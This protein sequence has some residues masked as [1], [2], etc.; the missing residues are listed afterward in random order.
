MAYSCG[1]CG[2]W[3]N[4]SESYCPGCRRGLRFPG[5]STREGCVVFGL[6]VFGV[7]FFFGSLFHRAHSA[8]GIEAA[9]GN[10]TYLPLILAIGGVFYA[11]YRGRLGPRW[12]WGVLIASVPIVIGNCGDRQ[13]HP[14]DP[15]PSDVRQWYAS[16]PGRL[17]QL[18]GEMN[19]RAGAGTEHPVVQVLPAGSLVRLGA[20]D[21][22][23]WSPLLRPLRADTMG[24][25]YS[26]SGNLQAVR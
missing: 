7:F 6:I 24:Y 8:I 25:L 20:P 12:R 26:R 9:P 18:R 17:H 13:F 23:G 15:V 2:T 16:G 5:G 1:N 22:G 14:T 21:A 3:L 10:W 19:V 11:V 4:G